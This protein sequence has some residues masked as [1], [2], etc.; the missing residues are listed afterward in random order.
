MVV[1]I[2]SVPS[3]MRLEVNQLEILKEKKVIDSYEVSADLSSYTLYWTAL[4]GG[5]VHEATVTLVRDF[6]S[7]VC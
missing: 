2:L 1:A 3:C 6:E 7:S 4:K 5:Q